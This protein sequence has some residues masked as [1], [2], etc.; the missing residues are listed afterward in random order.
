MKG[1]KLVALSGKV[2]EYLVT[3]LGVQSFVTFDIVCKCGFYR[4]NGRI[5]LSCVGL[6]DAGGSSSSD[7]ENST[8]FGNMAAKIAQK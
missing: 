1:E 5:D 7:V 4:R 6:T 8:I 2:A 3:R